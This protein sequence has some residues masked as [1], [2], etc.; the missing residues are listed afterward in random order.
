MKKFKGVMK[1]IGG[2]ALIGVSILGFDLMTRGI[3]DL[4]ED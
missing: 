3:S 2:T 4:V 1:I